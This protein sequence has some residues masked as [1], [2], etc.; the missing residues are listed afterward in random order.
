MTSPSLWPALDAHAHVDVGIRPGDLLA[1]RSVVFAATRSIAQAREAQQRAASDQLA[2]WGVGTH[3]ASATALKDFDPTEFSTLVQASAFVGEIGLDGG[4]PSR[5]PLQRDVLDAA[6][7]S[8]QQTPRV[9]SIHSYRAT[10]EVISSLRATPIRGVILH[11]WLGDETATT[12]AL[13]LGAYFS[14]NYS[15][16][17]HIAGLGIPLDRLLF[18]TDHP[19]GDRRSPAP[20]RPGRIEPAE[21]RVAQHLGIDHAAL[22]LASWQNLARLISETDSPPLLPARLRDLLAALPASGR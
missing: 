3:P 19:D 15:N 12:E 8:L 20:R 2:V 5:L 16:A 4:A 21:L 9:T 11:W 13:G 1:L 14:V 18:E 17:N 6:L 22:R 7:M 10:N